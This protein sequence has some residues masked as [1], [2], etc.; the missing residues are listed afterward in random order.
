MFRVN[1][2]TTL[3]DY[4]RRHYLPAKNLRESSR[5]QYEVQLRNLHKYAATLGATEPLRLADLSDGLVYGAMQW[6]VANELPAT[7]ANKLRRHINAIWNLACELEVLPKRPKNKAYRENLA[8]P[9][10]LL[11]EEL[12]KLLDAA[13][14]RD[15]YVGEVPAGQWWMTA[16]LFVYSLGARISAAYEVQTAK[17]D[18]DR[19]EVSLLA[20]TQKQHREQRLDLFPGVI[21]WLR[22]L[23][24][25][26]RGVKTVLGDWPFKIGWLRVQYTRLFVEAGLFKEAKDVPRNLKFH[27]LRKTLASQ[28]FAAGG[29][30][31]ACERMGHSSTQVTERYIDPRF[32]HKVRINELVKDPS[33]ARIAR[34]TLKIHRADAG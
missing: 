14:Q 27:A 2:E 7:T 10:A 25:K 9:L 32:K 3:V 30:P 31:A 12:D 34:P 21:Y 29:M 1:P 28:L 33:P 11:P 17:L 16:V 5:F 22:E 23:R 8:E 26:E 15:G 24:L 19:G 6:Q 20:E 18:L 4:F 13:G